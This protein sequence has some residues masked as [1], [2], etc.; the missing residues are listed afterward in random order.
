[1]KRAPWPTGWDA[2][3][4][5][6]L[7]QG[8]NRNDEDK[9]TILGCLQGRASR[10]ESGAEKV[11]KGQRVGARPHAVNTPQW[12]RNVTGFSSETFPLRPGIPPRLLLVLFR[13]SV[14]P[15]FP[16]EKAAEFLTPVR[17]RV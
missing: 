3:T 14:L 12:R 7:L 2:K 11:E 15:E 4:D 16:G 9:G 6:E 5:G 13:R 10:G 17:Y 8:G 1:M